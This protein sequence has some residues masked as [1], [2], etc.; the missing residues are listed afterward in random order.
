MS[1]RTA[2]LL[3]A[4]GTLCASPALAG[5]PGSV[6]G[7][8]NCAINPAFT[9]YNAPAELV[10]METEFRVH[11][12]LELMKSERDALWNQL[13]KSQPDL[14]FAQGIT[15]TLSRAQLIDI[16]V[17]EPDLGYR[18]RTTQDR[19]YQ[20]GA[21]TE[22]GL[23]IE[24][25]GAE[26]EKS[27][28]LRELGPGVA[29]RTK[30]GALVWATE[31][32]SPGATALKVGIRNFRMPEGAKLYAYS[33]S[34]E[35]FGPYQ[36]W[37]PNDTGEFWT[38][39]VVGDTAYLQLHLPANLVNAKSLQQVGFEIGDVGHMGS[40]FEPIARKLNPAALGEK[41][42]C[43]FNESCVENVNCGASSVINDAKNAVAEM[44]Y[45]SGAGYYICTGGLLADTDTSS[46][47]PYF[48]TANHC[49]S[50]G[51]EAQSLETIFDFEVACNT[52]TCPRYG[53]GFNV[54]TNGA[55][56]KATNS[57]SDY[58]LLQLAQTPGG[59]RA[60]LGWTNAEIAFSNGAALYRVSHPAGAP[61]AYSEH[62]VDTAKL[63]CGSWP[64]GN[65][66]YSTDTY[67]ATEGGSSGSP[68]LNS[69]G[70]VVGQLSGACGTNVN[71][72][73]DT[74]NNATVDGALAAYWSSVSSFLDPSN[75]GGDPPPGQCELL[76]KGA[77]CTDNSQCC[78]G[79]CK[80]R[81]GAKT[82]K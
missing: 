65:W 1:A 21:A 74:V 72:T 45:Q 68:V 13:M 30:G 75:G 49:I 47:I 40:R 56:I 46:V 26:L 5:N 9:E 58:T 32:H 63:T 39:T 16:G 62:D 53:D 52:G 14:S 8:E 33:A 29:Q 81:R 61:Q 48:L 77:S 23:P 24:F 4:L 38:H 2:A 66:I 41:A 3:A 18:L 34:G 59:T 35:A 70:Q 19:R 27:T 57:T 36:D 73:C 80:G 12:D 25:A 22:L 55:S 7:E 10:S 71:D 50:R 67:G 17:I 64:R 28:G 37:G 11:D 82:C 6:L 69:A 44:I 15:T 42:F 60:Y 20:V 54:R 79:N 51:K 76:P 78:S 43:S 31:V